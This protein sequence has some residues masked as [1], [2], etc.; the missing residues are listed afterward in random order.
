M[1]TYKKRNI[2]TK[3]A[4]LTAL[5]YMAGDALT[6]KE[7]MQVINANG[8]VAD[9]K[10]ISQRSAESRLCELVRFRLVN[11]EK[12]DGD[13]YTKYRM[14][15]RGYRT[16]QAGERGK[17]V[18]RIMDNAHHVLENKR[19]EAL[20]P[21]KERWRRTIEYELARISDLYYK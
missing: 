2:A 1:K 11:D 19:S 7:V 18:L 13:R 20:R 9:G 6:A 17:Q 8:L 16:L 12:N 15:D 4:V 10:I 3:W 5:S 14:S 21:M